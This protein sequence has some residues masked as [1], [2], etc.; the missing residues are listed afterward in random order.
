MIPKPKM[1]SVL[2]PKP[3]LTSTVV[4]W[5]DPV[6]SASVFVPSLS[7]LLASQFLSMISGK[8]NQIIF[9][10]LNVICVTTQRNYQFLES[11]SL[12]Y[13]LNLFSS[14]GLFSPCSIA[15]GIWFQNL[16]VC[17]GFSSKENGKRSRS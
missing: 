7:I 1:S 14:Y 6:F 5:Q 12:Y 16:L 15:S 8:Y 11:D 10:N 4:L 13:V 2:E 3:S 9:S 17:H